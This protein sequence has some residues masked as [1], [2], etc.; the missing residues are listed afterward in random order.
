MSSFCN[1]FDAARAVRISPA[2]VRFIEEK[3]REPVVSIERCLDADGY[4][5][6]FR[7]VGTIEFGSDYIENL[8]READGRGLMSRNQFEEM[9]IRDRLSKIDE[10]QLQPQ[11]AAVDPSVMHC[12]GSVHGIVRGEEF[13]RVMADEVGNAPESDADRFHRSIRKVYWYRRLKNES[14]K[15]L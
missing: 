9:V 6:Y 7:G 10:S 11:Q 1:Q 13:E 8:E 3:V 12:Q 2:V 5:F 14:K 15:K 4:R